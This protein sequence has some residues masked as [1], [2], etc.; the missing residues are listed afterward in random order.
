[1]PNPET[2][3][4]KEIWHNSE[5]SSKGKKKVQWHPGI[6]GAQTVSR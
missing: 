5:E 3:V 2:L 1:M 6:S 4:V